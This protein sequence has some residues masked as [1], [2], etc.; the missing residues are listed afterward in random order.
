MEHKSYIVTVYLK[1]SL[2]RSKV[3]KLVAGFMDF[4]LRRCFQR[5]RH[6]F[7]DYNILQEKALL[8]NAPVFLGSANEKAYA[9]NFTAQGSCYIIDLEIDIDEFFFMENVE[10]LAGDIKRVSA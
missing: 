2:N 4:H 9:V 10:F 5:H 1:S 6:G 3:N 8:D 7:K